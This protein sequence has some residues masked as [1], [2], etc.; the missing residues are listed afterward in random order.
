MHTV[1]GIYYFNSFIPEMVDMKKEN[2][3][4]TLNLILKI[5]YEEGG[6]IMI[7]TSLTGRKIHLSD[8]TVLAALQTLIADQHIVKHTD[9]DAYLM[10]LASIT[11]GGRVFYENGGYQDE[12]TKV[13][14]FIKWGKN[15]KM[16]WPV[17]VVFIILTSLAGI[18]GIVV[19]ILSLI[20]D[21]L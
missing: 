6:A 14:K 18:V 10:P 15:H 20:K 13:D 1:G 4:Y 9:I 12:T 16:L 17:V 2:F 11:G 3:R 5:Y 21:G 7:T 19:S 8:D